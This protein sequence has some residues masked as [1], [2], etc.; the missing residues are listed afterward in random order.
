MSEEK[1]MDED[2]FVNVGFGA[3]VEGRVDDVVKADSAGLVFATISSANKGDVRGIIY[4]YA[5][6][7][8]NPDKEENLRAC[9]SMQY[10]AHL[11]PPEKHPYIPLSS[12][13][14]PV[15]KNEYWIVKGG[16]SGGGPEHVKVFWMP[17]VAK[18]GV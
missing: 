3:K 10:V 12:F 11:G 18:I 7:T 8:S 6:L 13:C 1:E 14:M 5:G 16:V 17:I 9:A 4:G 2:R 15:G